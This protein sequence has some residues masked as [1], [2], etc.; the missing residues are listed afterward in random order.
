MQKW[1]LVGRR[2]ILRSC[3]LGAA[4]EVL[5]EGL[6]GFLEVVVGL[7]A[8]EVDGHALE[9]FLDG[10]A[11][12]LRFAGE[13]FAEG[14]V[15]GIDQ[16]CFSGFGVFEFHEACGRQLH[17]ARVH[18]GD[19]EH[20]VAFAKNLESVFEAFVQEVAHYHDHGATVQNLARVFQGH[21]RVGAVVFWLKVKDFADQAEHML[22][23]FFGRNEE[24]HLVGVNEEAD[25]VVVL[26]GGKGEKCREGRHDFAFHLLSASEFGTATG[27][28]HQKHGH[29]AFFDKLLHIRRAGSCGHVPVD[30]A[31]VVARHV[32]ADFAELHTVPLEGTVV[33]AGHHGVEC[34]ADAEFDAAD[35]F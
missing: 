32:F 17:F 20:I 22:A 7:D 28:D 29:F 14:G 26:D 18:H 8:H 34:A 21:L 24:F 35:G 19:C 3:L 27:V 25:L 1:R 9:E 10:L 6:H 12:A 16:E 23:A 15:T 5:N 11:L 33:G 13:C 2:L 4:A 30:G 31:H